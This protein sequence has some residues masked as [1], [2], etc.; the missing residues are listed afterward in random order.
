MHKPR[1]S[2]LTYPGGTRSP[3]GTVLV[4]RRH[5]KGCLQGKAS[6]HLSHCRG[7]RCLPRSAPVPRYPRRTTTLAGRGHRT[8]Q[9]C[10][11]ARHRSDLR[12]RAP[13][14]LRP[15]RS[16]TPRRIRFALSSQTPRCNS[17]PACTARRLSR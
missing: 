14:L 9:P 16:K 12:H 17:N 11:G 2:P 4:L 3:R 8:L 10:C 13:A 15:L 6:S 5:H 7:S 1:A